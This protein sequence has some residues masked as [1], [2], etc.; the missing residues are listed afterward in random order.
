VKH[1][2]HCAKDNQDAA[3]VCR[4]CDRR[5]DAATEAARDAPAGTTTKRC[6]F[7]AEEIQGAAVLCKHCGSDLARNIPATKTPE[8]RA[9]SPGVAAV[10]RLVITGA[11]QI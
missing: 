3:L 1:C 4:Y 6:P 11:C 7:C 10:L 9:W 8:P 2:P 5:M